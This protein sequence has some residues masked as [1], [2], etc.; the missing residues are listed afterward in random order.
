MH[1]QLYLR[2]GLVYVPTTAMVQRGFYQIIEPVAVVPVPNTLA[3]QRA[4]AETMER[5]N[6]KV[7]AP[8]PSDRTPPALV[9]YAGVKTWGS[10][11]RNASVWGIDE[12][13]REFKILGYRRDPPKGWT[14]D[15]T[16][17]ETF[18]AG[19][20]AAEAIDRMIAILQKAAAESGP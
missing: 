8:D 1:W 14:R 12:Q 19:T 7:P 5:G 9:K 13:E 6:P 10:F 4:L 17:D 20:S 15:K 2:M 11:V 16:K 3:I 18:P